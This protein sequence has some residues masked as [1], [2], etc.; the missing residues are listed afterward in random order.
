[1]RLEVNSRVTAMLRGEE[2]GQHEPRSYLGW[3]TECPDKL[4]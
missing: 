3:K 4:N 1:M 2:S